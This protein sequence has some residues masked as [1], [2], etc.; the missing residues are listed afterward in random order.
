MGKHWFL[1]WTSL[2][3][4]SS[5]LGT[6]CPRNCLTLPCPKN[7]CRLSLFLLRQMG[8]FQST[9]RNS[10]GWFW[11]RLS[12]GLGLGLDSETPGPPERP[13]C[14]WLSSHWCF[15]S[16]SP[17]FL[18]GNVFHLV[19]SG[20]RIVFQYSVHSV[21]APRCFSSRKSTVGWWA[22]QQWRW[23][24]S[25]HCLS[26]SGWTLQPSQFPLKADYCSLIA[27]EKIEVHRSKVTW[28]RS[29]IWAWLCKSALR[30][31][32]HSHGSSPLLYHS[33]FLALL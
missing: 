21:M 32:L 8:G 33:G 27:E 28:L 20:W 22:N 24:N 12:I 26:L 18:L 14:R 7:C 3:P 17:S 2:W 11:A 16:I 30:G 31:L 10:A 13:A 9:C 1:A 15:C 23:D 19:L 6:T 29:F 4:Y 25:P 5:F